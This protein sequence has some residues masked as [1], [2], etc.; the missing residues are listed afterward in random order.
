MLRAD[1][2]HGGQPVL[3]AGA[4]L[5]AARGVVVMLHGRGA[6]ADDMLA[7]A[8]V[9]ARPQFAY[10]A[11]QAAGHTWYPNRFVAP[12][13]A[14]EPWLSSAL[15][16]VGRV[17]HEAEGLGV[18]AERM[19]LLGF[20][21]GACLAI[22]FAARNARRYGGIAGLSGGLIGPDGTPRSYHG[23]FD[24]APAF[25]GCDERDPH[26]PAARVHETAAVL[27]RMGAHVT[28]R[29]YT[30][31]GHMVNDDE[32]GHVRAMLDGI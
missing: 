1:D 12:I 13:S 29:L 5:D 21:Q 9:L 4:P 2:P 14:N 19:V 15:A 10:L 8:S 16:L 30:N 31:M 18:A 7:L 28:E 20:S 24:G 11:P 17:V 32:I 3:T 26:I 23:T 27:R 6:E 22:E 25:F